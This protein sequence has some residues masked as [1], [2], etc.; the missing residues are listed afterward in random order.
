MQPLDIGS[1]KQ[2][3]LDDR[4]IATGK[5]V[6]LAMNPPY[7]AAEPVVTVDA[8]WEDP[9]DTSFGIYSSVLG[10]DDGRVRMWYHVRRARED[11]E[12][13]LDQACVG[14]AES[15]DGIH[16]EKPVLNLVD[17]GG[18]TANN[19]VLPSKLGGSSVWIDPQ[20]PGGRAL[21]EPVEGLQS[22]SGDAVPHAQLA[23]RHPLEIP[24][25]TPRC[26]IWISSP[27]GAARKM[28]PAPAG[29][30]WTPGELG[31][32]AANRA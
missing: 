18:S 7:Q 11:S 32:P 24:S 29:S 14:Y 23:G 21:Q 30:T 13:S 15:T 3:F 31:T 22:R 28:P 1:S 26:A 4:F 20:C 5:G 19:I 25:P 12:L 16:F 10:E 8:P 2:L 17:E 6:E 27:A 9:S